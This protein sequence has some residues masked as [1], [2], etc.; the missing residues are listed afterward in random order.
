MFL[1]LLLI[2][3]I[4]VA[5]AFLGLGFNIIFRK[6]KF[7]QTG[8]GS[9]PEMQKRGLS[10]AKC[11]EMQAYQM[12]RKIAETKANQK[13]NSSEMAGCAGCGVTEMT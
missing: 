12:S 6:K 8:V 3:L 5:F 9:N 4:L 7:P 11:D 1:K 13:T 10:C 2:S